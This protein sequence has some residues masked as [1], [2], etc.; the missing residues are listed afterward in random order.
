MRTAGV[1]VMGLFCRAQVHQRSFFAKPKFT[2]GALLQSPNSTLSQQRLQACALVNFC[3]HLLLTPIPAK[4]LQILIEIGA[5]T[6]KFLLV[7]FNKPCWSI[8]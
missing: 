4:L 5:E 8:Q 7:H 6:C 1:E 2:K 3:L